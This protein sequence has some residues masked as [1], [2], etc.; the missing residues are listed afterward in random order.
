MPL[1]KPQLGLADHLSVGRQVAGE[2]RA[3]AWLALQRNP[4]AVKFGQGPHQ[5]QP[6]ARPATFPTNEP[7]EDMRLHMERNAAT[8]VGDLKLYLARR[9]ARRQ[10]DRAAAQ[11]LDQGVFHQVIQNL[12]QPPPIS[13]D[14][15]N[16]Y[17]ALDGQ[18]N[19]LGQRDIA[20]ALARLGQQLGDIHVTEVQGHFVS[21]DLG[22]DMLWENDGKGRFRDVALARGFAAQATGN[23]FLEG[24]LHGTM[25]EPDKD[26]ST[27]VGGNGFIGTGIPDSIKQG[28]EIAARIAG[29]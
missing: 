22:H 10:G 24:T 13:S 6:Q 2:G 19:P 25:P 14:L 12:R 16:V 7:V 11:S 20:P 26:P 1:A 3:S 21:V 29:A 4:A 23:Y 17:G 8:G 9:L 27:Y 18:L 5:R 15:T 28:E